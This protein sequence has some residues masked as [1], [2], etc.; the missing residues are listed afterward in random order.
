METLGVTGRALGEGTDAEALA[1]GSG[2]EIAERY[3]GMRQY[4]N[5]EPGQ[6]RLNANSYLDANYEI[7]GELG[8][9]SNLLLHL[10]NAYDPQWVQLSD[11]AAR[12]SVKAWDGTQ[13]RDLPVKPNVMSLDIPLASLVD[14]QRQIHLRFICSADFIFQLPWAEAY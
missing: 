6:Y 9:Q 7:A 3:G 1:G 5:D 4:D 13:W 12:L 10:Q 11:L 8:E 14:S 2:F